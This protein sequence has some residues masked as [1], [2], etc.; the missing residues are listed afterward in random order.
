MT[1]H[2]HA[3]GAE[4]KRLAYAIG[5]LI[6]EK[7]VYQFMPTCAYQIGGYVLDREGNLHCDDGAAFGHLLGAL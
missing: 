5:E 3:T 1:L 7:P 6:G 2:F 4:R